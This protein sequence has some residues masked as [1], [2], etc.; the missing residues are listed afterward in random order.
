MFRV[1]VRFFRK[2][3]PLYEASH[4]HTLP[5]QESITGIS[6]KSEKLYDPDKLG[7]LQNLVGKHVYTAGISLSDSVKKLAKKDPN[8]NEFLKN[9]KSRDE[10]E[11]NPFDAPKEINL[12]SFI[13][14][15]VRSAKDRLDELHMHDQ[16]RKKAI[17]ENVYEDQIKRFGSHL[18]QYEQLEEDLEYPEDRTISTKTQVKI[19]T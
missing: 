13:K 19:G 5:K 7:K 4:R 15:P 12:K 8:F 16:L 6:M 14:D 11:L 3:S 1:C 18:Y 9:F 2:K 10:P 17:A